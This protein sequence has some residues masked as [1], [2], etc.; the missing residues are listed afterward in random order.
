MQSTVVV[1]LG[2]DIDTYW[3]RGSPP[4]VVVLLIV[5]DDYALCQ[6]QLDNDEEQESLNSSE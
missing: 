4:L 2:S 5:Q 3:Y 1:L 6:F